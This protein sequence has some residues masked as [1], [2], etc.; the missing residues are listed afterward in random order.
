MQ[1]PAHHVLPVLLGIVEQ[2]AEWLEIVD[3]FEAGDE[4]L[5]P[6]A[7]PVEGRRHAGEHGVAAD[8]RHL[9]GDQDR[10]LGRLLAERLVRMPDVGAER[11]VGLVVAELDQHRDVFVLRRE[12]MHGQFAE[13]AAEVDQV[14]RA[15]V[16][17]AED[18]QLVL[19]QRVF[20]GVAHLVGHRLAKIDA[21]D[22]GAEVGADPRD[23]DA[24]MLRHDGTALEA[25]DGLIHGCKPLFWVSQ[26]LSRVSRGRKVTVGWQPHVFR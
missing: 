5:H 24:G 13:P 7:Q 9:L 23:G 11:R 4:M 20:D 2:L 18:E 21:G 6:V 25:V 10:R 12:R 15:D 17:I 22:L 1:L 14:L 19:G 3:R 16:L 8:R 26:Q